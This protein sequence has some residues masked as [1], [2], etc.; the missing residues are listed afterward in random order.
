MARVLLAAEWENQ[1]TLCAMGQGAFR[2]PG[3]RA[4][5]Q[6]WGRIEPAP[7]VPALAAPEEADLGLV[8][9]AE[10][11]EPPEGG[12]VP[13]LRAGDP[14]GGKGRDLLFVLDDGDVPPA[15][16]LRSLRG[17]VL[18][19]FTEKAALPALE[20]ATRRD[21]HAPALGAEHPL[22]FLSPRGINPWDAPGSRTGS[23]ECPGGI[24]APRDTAPGSGGGGGAK[25]PGSRQGAGSVRGG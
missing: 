10:L 3:Y 15:P 25:N 21:H 22:L 6:E 16:G 11:A 8:G 23:R 7:H 9:G 5:I 14:D 1:S 2:N 24:G 20:L 19:E 12:V 4:L 13:A 18:R 17:I